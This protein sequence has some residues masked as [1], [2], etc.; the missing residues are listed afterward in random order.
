[1]YEPRDY[2]ALVSGDLINKIVVLEESDLQVLSSAA[3]DSYE[4]LDKI[5]QEVKDYIGK[6]PEFQESLEPISTDPLA[7]PMINHMIRASQLGKVGPMASVAGTVSQYLGEEM[8]K[9]SQEVIIENGGDIY[10]NCHEDKD[11]LVYAGEAI[12]SNKIAITIGSHMMPVGICTSSG[13]VGHSL[14]FGR[15]DAVVVVSKDTL[16]ADAVATGT[17]NIVK[18]K[19]DINKGIE[20]A[21]NIQGVLGIVIIVGDQVGLWGQVTLAKAQ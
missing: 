4:Y 1:M 14:S 20:F 8:A 9:Y 16:L 11:V 15:A 21:K 12:L 10:M 3:F 5:R 17:G 6:R 2:R 18:C 13:T 7:S 19:E